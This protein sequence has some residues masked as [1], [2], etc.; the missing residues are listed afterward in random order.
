[1]EM[2][3]V[4]TD[5]VV[6]ERAWKSFMTKLLSEWND[7]ILWVRFRVY[8]CPEFFSPHLAYYLSQP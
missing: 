6:I 3:T 1:M 2:E 5:E 4:W 7:L 8:L